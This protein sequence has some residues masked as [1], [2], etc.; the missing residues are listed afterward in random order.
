M[1]Q[2]VQQ[3]EADQVKLEDTLLNNP[4]KALQLPL[5]AR[6]IESDRRAMKQ[7]CLLYARKWTG[8]TDSCSGFSE[9]SH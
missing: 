4:A 1:E 8:K 6:D 2:D 5:L 3:L 9:P 7:L